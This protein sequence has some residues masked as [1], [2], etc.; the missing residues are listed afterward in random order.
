M[1]PLN[2]WLLADMDFFFFFFF[3][4]VKSYYSPFP[5]KKLLFIYFI[6]A[7]QLLKKGAEAHLEGITLYC[8]IRAGGLRFAEPSK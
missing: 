4:L 7:W 5:K 3:F 2:N 6:I 8:K 1:L